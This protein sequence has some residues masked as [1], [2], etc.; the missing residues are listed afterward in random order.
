M[1][2]SIVTED[3]NFILVHERTAE[4]KAQEM[5]EA[6]KVPQ[7]LAAGWGGTGSVVREPSHMRA[8]RSGTDNVAFSIPTLN[9][10]SGS[11]DYSG[12]T[13]P[14]VWR[15]NRTSAAARVDALSAGGMDDYDIPAF[16]RK[17]ADFEPEPSSVNAFIRKG[18]DKL[19]SM[20]W[21]SQ[22]FTG[23]KRSQPLADGY[24]GITPAGVEKWLSINHE[25][26][27]PK[28]YADL[29]DMGLGLAICEWLEFEIGEGHDEA[30]VVAIFLNVLRDFG[31]VTGNGSLRG[32]D[33][34]RR[35][36]SNATVR[37]GSNEISKLIR[38]G[39]KD[40]T[41]QAWPLA[42]VNFPEPAV[43]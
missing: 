1:E 28:S 15:T 27:W 6:H 26:F 25:S 24:T 14:S 10:V 35:D 41:A 2:V 39:L 31:F 23:S 7:M 8:F 18:I 40:V 11:P 21:K 29:R 17:T 4:E 5:P 33:A 3:T 12:M 13:T 20:F 32:G 34:V 43:A 42:V 38:T 19:N 36:S 16:L 37:A 30:M 22:T 9:C